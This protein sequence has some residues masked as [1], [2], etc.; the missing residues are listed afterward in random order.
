MKIIDIIKALEQCDPEAEAT[1]VYEV[2]GEFIAA[3]FKIAAPGDELHK[4]LCR[5]MG[6]SE[7]VYFDAA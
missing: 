6:K 7:R 3:D 1:V 5:I 2:L 4:C